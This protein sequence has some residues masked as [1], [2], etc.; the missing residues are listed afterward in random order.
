LKGRENRIRI[1]VIWFTGLP[2][3]GKTT[4]ALE[5]QKHFIDMG[6]VSLVLDGGLCLFIDRVK[7]QSPPH[8]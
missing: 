3:S 5:L 7:K 1:P 4:H 8:A 2:S 6:F